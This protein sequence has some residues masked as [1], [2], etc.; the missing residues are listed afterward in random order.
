[1]RARR[2]I[3]VAVPYQK[4]SA[5]TRRT[6]FIAFG[7]TNSIRQAAREAKIDPATLSRWAR[8][9]RHRLE[10]AESV[11]VG[12]CRAELSA[13]TAL[14]EGQERLRERLADPRT[15]ALETAKIIAFCTDALVK[16]YD[17]EDA[18]TRDA[19]A[20]SRRREP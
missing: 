3:L 2:A 1:V 16:A 9:P 11:L 6:A 10:L 15:T 20:R 19:V 5:A 7:A 8:D 4:L 18:V 13:M 12:R 14:S 17:Y